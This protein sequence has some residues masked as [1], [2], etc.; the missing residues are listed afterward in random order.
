MSLDL[1]YCWLWGRRAYHDAFGAH[2]VGGADEGL[3]VELRL[4]EALGDAE[5]RELD[6]AFGVQ[7][8]VVRLDVQV[9]LLRDRV[10]VR[11]AVQHLRS[12]QAQRRLAHLDALLDQVFQRALVHELQDHLHVAFLK[13]ASVEVHQEVARDRQHAL[14]VEAAHGGERL[15][16]VEQLAALVFLVDVDALDRH[17]AL[18]L[19]VV[20]PVHQSRRAFAHDRAHHQV[21]RQLRAPLRTSRCAPRRLLPQTRASS[22]RAASACA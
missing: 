10:Q 17:V 13:V 12:H 15:E 7:Q 19:L 21:L 2:V 4:L 9:R 20:R 5:V 22:P 3:H 16:V 18:E 8:D 14:I 6:E 1:L 11:Q